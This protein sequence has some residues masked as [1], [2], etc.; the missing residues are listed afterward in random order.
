MTKIHEL[1]DRLKETSGEQKLEIL[2]RL[3]RVYVQKSPSK[4]IEY[5]KEILTLSETLNNTLERSRAF[6]SL[7]RIYSNLEMFDEAMAYYQKGIKAAQAIKDHKL[8]KKIYKEL[9]ELYAF[10]GDYESALRYYKL[11]FQINA[12]APSPHDTFITSKQKGD[13]W[14]TSDS[15]LLN[16]VIQFLPHPLLIINPRNY[17]V[18][19]CN[20]S[21][22][23]KISKEI[24]CHSFLRHRD[25]PCQDEGCLCP[26]REVVEG[27]RSVQTVHR[28]FDEEGNDLYHEIYAY[29]ILNDQDQVRFVVEYT[30][31]ITK[32]KLIEED[33]RLSKEQLAMVA[34]G[35]PALISFV[36][37]EERYL[38]VNK[39]YADWYGYSRED[40]LGKYVSDILSEKVYKRAAKYIKKVLKGEQVVFENLVYKDGKRRIIK[41]VYTP[42]QDITGE[43]KSFFA[44]IVD[45]TEEK[46]AEKSLLELKKAMETM[47][48][49]ITITDVQRR[50]KYVNSTDA[51]M[52]GYDRNELLGK[53]VDIYSP[54]ELKDPM[55][56][57]QIRQMQPLI[58]ESINLRKDGSRFPVK[59]ISD[60]VKNNKGEPIAIVTTCEDITE[61]KKYE[62]ALLESEKKL[63]EANAS[64]D[65]FFSII[66]NDLKAPL[67]VMIGY[68]DILSEFYDNISEADRK[69][70]ILGINKTSK[71]LLQL[72][73]NLI[74]WSSS[75]A[76]VLNY[77]PEKIDLRYIVSNNLTSLD[78]KAKSKNIQLSSYVKENSFIY[79]DINM[80]STVVK[81]LLSNAIKFTPEGGTVKVL[82]ESDMVD[83]YE[84]SIVDN[85][86]GISEER[87]DGLFRIDVHQSAYGT[88]DEEK[89][90][91]LGLILCKEFIERHGGKIWV[92]SEVGKGTTFR[93]TLPKPS[94]EK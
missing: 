11:H 26:V 8:L 25:F 53:N 65:R 50:I 5:Y 14:V 78:E 22:F 32:Q 20:R 88:L 79:V 16:S 9:S 81:N 23:N 15:D 70:S 43:V 90:T 19:F 67:T 34:D 41:V 63:R 12:N 30:I 58:R 54:P 82:V 18:E 66:A 55:T 56:L 3:A 28:H 73:Q 76:G 92:E 31:D 29:P 1:E 75:Q 91:G 7:G 60:V 4:S 46:L 38:Y 13:S 27:K 77:E 17:K 84:V 87:K 93:F 94:E 89:G 86:I 51:R 64:K 71:K 44:M 48:L 21:D 62:Q 33:L 2:K 68:A 57:E 37:S 59:L 80:I 72:L 36:D 40:I 74:D 52:H 42:N 85:G 10:Q 47:R 6:D 61:R 39:A 24:T 69:S 35:L 49:G 45:I 83:F